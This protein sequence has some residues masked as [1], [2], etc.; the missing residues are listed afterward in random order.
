VSRWLKKELGDLFQVNGK[1]LT[2]KSHD[3]KK[4]RPR[5]WQ[6]GPLPDLQAHWLAKYGE[7]LGESESTEST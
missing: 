7:D 3:G 6:F 1:R 2:V 4:L 5:T